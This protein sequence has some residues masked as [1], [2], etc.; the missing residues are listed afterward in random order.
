M[1][2]VVQEMVD[3]EAAGVVFS[4]DPIDGDPSQV[5]VT[6]NFGL[7]ESVVSGR[8]E[9][10]TITVRRTF[11]GQLSVGATTLGAKLTRT[12]LSDDGGVVEQ[13]VE[14]SQSERCSLDEPFV[15]QLAQL[16]VHM[17]KAFGGPRDLEFAVK[18]GSIHLLQVIIARR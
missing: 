8:A 6:S 5:I 11:N 7:G 12:V 14:Q 13:D 16:A 1:G 15:L 9:P 10:D 2:V 4:V 18:Q 17:E 3:A